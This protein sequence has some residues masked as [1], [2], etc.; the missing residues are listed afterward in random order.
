MPGGVSE[1]FGAADKICSQADIYYS[2]KSSTA[3]LSIKIILFGKRLHR[4][5][6]R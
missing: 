6:Q 1:E 5:E 2:D 3:G 4:G